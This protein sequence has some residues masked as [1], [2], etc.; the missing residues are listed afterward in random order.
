L[1]LTRALLP[2][3][4]QSLF[5]EYVAFLPLTA[6]LLAFVGGWRWRQRRGV[7]PV[8][9]LTMMGLFLALGAFNPLYWLLARLPGFNLFRVPARWLVLYALGAALLAGAGW[10]VISGGQWKEQVGQAQRPWRWGLSVLLLL[11]VWGA[12][13]V[14]LTRFIP[15]GSE[16]PAEW[17]SWLTWLGWTAELTI[18]FL[19]LSWHQ[20]TSLIKDIRLTPPHLFFSSF[21][22]I[23]VF[24]FLASR[25]HPYNNLTAPQAYFSL[26]PPITRLQAA[27]LCRPQPCSL[28]DLTADRQSNYL[29]NPSTRQPI[30]RFLSLSD[31]FFDPGDQGE[32]EAIYGQ[33][34]S[35]DALYDY[36]VATKQK[37]IIAP[38]LPLAYGLASVDGF[39]GGILP[40]ASYSQL[41]RLILPQDVTT[42]DGRLREHLPAVPEAHW[43]DLF[44]ARYTI[45]DKTG[46]VWRR[47][48]FFDRQHP[49]TLAQG[50]TAAVGYVPDFEATELWLMA[51]AE[52]GTVTVVAVDGETWRLTPE[53][54]QPD[55]YRV[56]WPGAAV[57]KSITLSSP[58]A[59]AS[60]P[61][62]GLGL[63]L[64]DGRDGTF[65]PLVLGNYRLIH[66]GDVKIYE[67]LDVLPRA[68]LVYDWQWQPDVAASVA[69]MNAPDFDPRQT[70]VLIG[71]GE[72]PAPVSRPSGQVEILSYEPERIVL[73][74]ESETAGLLL[75][76]DAYYPG[77][78]T[79]VVGR[80]APLY[81]ADGLFRGV[82][83][84]A[85]EHEIVFN[86]APASL[87]VGWIVS[88]VGF[89][90][91]LLLMA[92]WHGWLLDRR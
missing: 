77:W 82:M 3:Y 71:E 37:E 22:L 43:L 16:A 64:V 6:L 65:R 53:L 35:I 2:T 70:V 59:S 49:V 90:F 92:P 85:G 8:L 28:A 73:G 68:F 81:Q 83:I 32:I 13:S 60:S 57:A 55:L 45:T 15:T 31:I 10:D 25:S 23:V 30:P 19:L 75:L 1:L 26:R 66:S 42:S 5:S 67:N 87:A 63:S 62:Q 12:L 40:L 38:N 7:L 14:P 50:Q 74:T 4:S 39:D 44:N 54:L 29:S 84:P 88:A 9:V 48:V 46:D 18:G 11:M 78:E 20:K 34:L 52:P 21:L 80:P 41:M 33:Q 56:S 17:P 51:S 36:V 91:W 72:A 58:P 27:T 61:L 69:A 89:L 24:L 79:A 76:I 47:E 86:F